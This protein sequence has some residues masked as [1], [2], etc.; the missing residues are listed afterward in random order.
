MDVPGGGSRR[1]DVPALDDVRDDLPDVT[2]PEADRLSLLLRWLAAPP[3]PGG[4]AAGVRG[5]GGNEP[6]PAAA[7]GQHC[8]QWAPTVHPACPQAWHE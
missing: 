8:F 7:R 3:A 6:T 4:L 2:D 5:D 1:G